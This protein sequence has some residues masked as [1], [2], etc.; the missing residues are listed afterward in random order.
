MIIRCVALV[1]AFVFLAS[2]G[3]CHKNPLESDMCNE[4]TSL[5]VLKGHPGHFSE[6]NSAAGGSEGD[7]ADPDV[8]EVQLGGGLGL[9]DDRA[10]DQAVTGH[11]AA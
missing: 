5:T 1:L 3:G 8:G 4:G 2:S 7:A 6:H 11:D 9:E 10:S